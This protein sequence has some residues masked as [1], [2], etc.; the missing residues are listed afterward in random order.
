VIARILDLGRVADSE[1]LKGWE[2]AAIKLLGSHRPPKEKPGVSLRRYAPADLDQCLA[3]LDRYKETVTLALVWD[4]KDLAWELDYPGVSETL[5]YEKEGRVAGMINFIWHKHIG[6]TRE[7]WA[8]V[9]H[10]AYPDLS[11][12]ERY[13]FV[14]AFL[15]YCQ[16]AGCVGT[17][18]WN[19]KYYPLRPFYRSRFFPYFRAVNLVSWTFNPDISLA[20]IPDVYEVQV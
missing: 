3:L 9:N 5:V 10:V 13:G 16:K 2:K 1:G 15:G 12:K 7:L 11:G 19:R 20:K 8:W 4:K 17:I 18:E 14:Q 6:K